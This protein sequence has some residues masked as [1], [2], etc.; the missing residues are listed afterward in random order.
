LAERLRTHTG[1]FPAALALALF[2]ATVIADSGFGKPSNWPDELATLAPFAIVA[3]A[4]TPSI[5]SGGGGI[6]ISIGPLTIFANV[7]L[8][9]WFLPHSALKSPWVAIPLLVVIC[10]AIGALNGLLVTVLRY[11]PVIATLCMF[12]V[13]AGVVVKIAPG[14]ASAPQTGWLND[15]GG[16]VGPLPGGLLMMAT[17]FAIWFV[18]SRTAFHRNLYATGGNDV[19][20]FSAGVNVYATR[21]V[22]YALGGC[23]AAFAGVALTALVQTTQS[24]NTTLYTLVALAAVALG[25]TQF[26][27]GR[28]GLVASLLGACCIYLMQTLLVALSVPA[29]WLNVAYG[30]LLLIGVVVGSMLVTRNATRVTR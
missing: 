21:I 7:V 20:A 23:F 17:P 28:G 4:S 13:L 24:G 1:L 15:L 19:T 8:I 25:G 11:R 6:D 10:G 9:E 5:L 22:A 30:G 14:P 18:L 16:K 3:M 27:G 26:S 29:T 12:F 2:A